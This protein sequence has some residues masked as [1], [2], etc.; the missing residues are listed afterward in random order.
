[1]SAELVKTLGES[2]IF[3]T[4]CL[5]Y[6]CHLRPKFPLA[7]KALAKRDKYFW[8]REAQRDVDNIGKFPG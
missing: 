5:Y 6:R 3:D 4:L 7:F 1:M 2:R 8:L